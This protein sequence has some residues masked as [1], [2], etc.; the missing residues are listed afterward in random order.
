MGDNTLSI[1]FVVIIVAAILSAVLLNDIVCLALTPLIIQGCFHKKLNPV[2]FLLGLACASNIGSALTLIGNPQNILIGQ[3]LHIPFGQYLLYAFVPCLLGLVVTWYLIKLLTRD[4][5]FQ[6]NKEINV[7]AIPF[8][9]WQSTK[10][11][12]VILLLLVIFLFS[13]Y[14]VTM[15]PSLQL[16]FYS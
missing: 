5:W 15:W 1:A 11:I 16:E 3:V 12:I 8:N 7:T 4:N 10:G 6:K 14:R 2:P 9:L 13:I